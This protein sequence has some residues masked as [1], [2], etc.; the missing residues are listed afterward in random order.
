[1][2][3]LEKSL[4]D[5]NTENLKIYGGLEALN[6]KQ[7]VDYVNK[8]IV[9][10]K[11]ESDQRKN[12]ILAIW[13]CKYFKLTPDKFPELFKE[14]YSLNDFDD[15]KFNDNVD[16]KDPMF[17]LLYPISESYDFEKVPIEDLLSQA[18]KLK[19]NALRNSASNSNMGRED[20][21]E[22]EEREGIESDVSSVKG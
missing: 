18:T 3:K 6:F 22:R 16:E 19:A 15:E 1:M 7:T 9:S 17:N 12:Q 5:D 11:S 20:R 4:I 2:A 14:D 8:R 21:E 13:L 10:K